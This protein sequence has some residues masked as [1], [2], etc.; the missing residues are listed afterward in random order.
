MA[1]QARDEITLI[2]VNDGTNG[3]NG[4]NGASTVTG[5]V[6]FQ[7]LQA[8]RP[9]TPSAASY[10]TATSTFTGLTTNWSLSRPAVD[11]SNSGNLEWHSNFTA[12]IPATGAQTVTFST[13]TGIQQVSTDIQSDNFVAGESGWR[14]ERDTGDAEFGSATIRGT[15]TANQIQLGTGLMASVD[16]AVV[17]NPAYIRDLN[18]SGR[19]FGDIMITTASVSENNV[20]QNI[21]VDSISFDSNTNRSLVLTTQ[22]SSSAGDPEY[23]VIVYGDINLTTGGSSFRS[24][25]A[26]LTS[27]RGNIRVYG[28]IVIEGRST[29]TLNARNGCVQVMGTVSNPTG[30]TFNMNTAAGNICS[31]NP[32]P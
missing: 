22:S 17:V 6:Y 30:T 29:L 10:N 13:P 21:L 25:T 24:H 9:A 16:N 8:A 19:Q 4:V 2:D 12:T 28:N 15:L 18:R 11:I 3:I 26:I 14:I 32:V 20:Q 27:A 23:D 1:R 7:T 31:A 5:I